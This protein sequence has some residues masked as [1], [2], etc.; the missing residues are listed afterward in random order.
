MSPINK[1]HLQSLSFFVVFLLGVLFGIFFRPEG[2]YEL[3]INSYEQLQESLMFIGTE[4]TRPQ[5]GEV[6][7]TGKDIINAVKGKPLQFVVSTSVAD[8]QPN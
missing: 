7:V 8:N 3:A 5:R 1:R 4:C 2:Q 6:V